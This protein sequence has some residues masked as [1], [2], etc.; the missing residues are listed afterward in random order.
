M[1]EYM[2]Y[3]YYINE[4]LGN[5]IAENEFEYF[6]QKAFRWLEY[7]SEKR[8]NEPSESIKMAGCAICDVLYDF[9]GREGISSESNDGYNV[10]YNSD[11]ESLNKL[12]YRAAKLYL[13]DA[14]LYRGLY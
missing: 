6:A 13:D 14:L 5:K 1:N 2:D 4:Y 9:D 7:I 3:D 10:V 12:I 11:G 8:I